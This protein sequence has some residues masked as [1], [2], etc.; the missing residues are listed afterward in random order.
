MNREEARSRMEELT[1]IILHHN[2]R[3]YQLDAPEISDA[4]YDGLMRELQTLEIQ[5]PD[6]AAPDSPTQARRCPPPGKI[7]RR[8]PPHPHA[9][10][11]QRLLR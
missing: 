1:A 7:P 11:R 4:E 9:Q 5:Y 8:H 2:R 10:P 6:L 3:Y